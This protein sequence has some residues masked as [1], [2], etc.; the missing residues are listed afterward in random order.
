MHDFWFNLPTEVVTICSLVHFFIVAASIAQPEG[1]APIAEFA[2][3][4]DPSGDPQKAMVGMMQVRWGVWSAPQPR[5][6]TAPMTQT[7][8]LLHLPLYSS[9][10]TTSSSS[11]SS[12]SS[13]CA[14]LLL[15]LGLAVHEFRHG[16]MEPR[17]DVGSLRRA[18]DMARR[19]A[20]RNFHGTFGAIVQSHRPARPVATLVDLCSNKEGFAGK[21]SY[22]N[23]W[24]CWWDI[25]IGST[26]LYG[27]SIEGRTHQL[28]SR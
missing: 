16:R 1:T 6:R 14:L 12:S 28:D 25:G 22:C 17:L 5:L 27:W 3:V 11:S 10:S 8:L 23:C 20:S 9:S 13:S 21:W 19:S 24:C 4:F 15:L 2:D 18:M 7:E 26:L